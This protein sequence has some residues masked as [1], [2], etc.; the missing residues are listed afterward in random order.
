MLYNIDLKNLQNNNKLYFT[1]HSLV[2]LWQA[3][4]EKAPCLSHRPGAFATQARGL[5]RLQLILSVLGIRFGS[6]AGAGGILGT[7]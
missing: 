1:Q 4:L 2:C 5:E 7:S 3:T 6:V